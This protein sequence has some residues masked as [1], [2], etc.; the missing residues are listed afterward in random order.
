MSNYIP[1]SYRFEDLKPPKGEFVPKIEFGPLWNPRYGYYMAIK[2]DTEL[3]FRDLV[4]YEKI[5]YLVTRTVWY[6]PD[7]VFARLVERE[8][9]LQWTDTYR[10]RAF[11]IPS[12]KDV[13]EPS[14]C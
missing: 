3:H 11:S 8:K 5:I 4:E 2:T 1:H 13:R 10:P 9:F 14:T 12:G 7:W 6:H